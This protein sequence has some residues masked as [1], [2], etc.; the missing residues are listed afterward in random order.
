MTIDPANGPKFGRLCPSA[1]RLA[2]ATKSLLLAHIVCFAPQ[3]TKQCLHNHA[4]NVIGLPRNGLISS[5]RW[6]VR[7]KFRTCNSSVYLVSASAS[8]H[9]V[10][11]LQSPPG[12]AWDMRHAFRRTKPREPCMGND[13]NGQFCFCSCAWHIFTL[14]GLRAASKSTYPP[15]SPL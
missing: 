13:K 8:C 10:C 5:V 1:E 11:S 4:F 2:L 12:G 14:S 15:K 3:F 7:I 9:A 6:T